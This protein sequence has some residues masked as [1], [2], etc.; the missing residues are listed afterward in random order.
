MLTPLGSL[1]AAPSLRRRLTSFD[2]H[3]NPKH[4][5]IHKLIMFLVTLL[6]FV[7]LILGF[8]V[9]GS[10]TFITHFA[11]GVTI[12]I[13]LFGQV[14]LG[15]WRARLS[16]I[17]NKVSPQC[18]YERRH[19]ISLLHKL[20]GR[21]MWVLAAINV[22]IGFDIYPAFGISGTVIAGLL[23]VPAAVLMLTGPVHA[24]VTQ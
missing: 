22:F 12:T 11:L 15:A 7:A 20:T 14:F 4:T 23:M 2:T 19:L 5:R 3:S 1:F 10:R 18:G 17:A 8:F 6:V 24:K 13:L 9:L 21:S 16:P